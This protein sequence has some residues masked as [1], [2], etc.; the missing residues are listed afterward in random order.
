M[1]RIASFQTKSAT[2]RYLDAIEELEEFSFYEPTEEEDLLLP[3]ETQEIFGAKSIID[4]ILNKYGLESVANEN[5]IEIKNAVALGPVAVE[6]L[7]N[8]LLS[9]SNPMEMAVKSLMGDSDHA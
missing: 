3:I 8:A 4:P 7:R 9:V 1:K 2:K 5:G 6:E